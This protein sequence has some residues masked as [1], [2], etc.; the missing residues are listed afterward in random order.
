MPNLSLLIEQ[1]EKYILEKK[2]FLEN[3]NNKEISSEIWKYS[4]KSFQVILMLLY[5]LF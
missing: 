1:L 2:Y 3:K 5:K 4:I